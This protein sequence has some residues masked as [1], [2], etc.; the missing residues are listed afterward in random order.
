[1]DPD[2][3]KR[4]QTV[5]ALRADL[6][7][8]MRGEDNFPRQ[9]FA[10]GEY[11]MREG[12]VGNAAYILVYGR[13]QV[14]KQIKGKR[15][16]LRM[17]GPGDVLGETSILASTP[18][19]ASVLALTDVVA[20]VVTAD[21]LERE[22]DAMKP[23][24]GSFIRA[25]ARRFTDVESRA[26]KSTADPVEIANLALMNLRTWGRRGHEHGHAMSVLRLC[27]QIAKF[28][29]LSENAVLKALRQYSQFDIDLSLDRISVI[30]E[31]GLLDE[32]RRFVWA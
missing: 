8:F 17:L 27:G 20:V 4:Y 32:L 2:P 31:Q 11:L 10:K 23:W 25:L 18:R 22:V 12:E 21:A 13:C 1:M 24:M 14:C 30:D 7:G 16:S 29:G 5:E 19:T 26:S 6:L 15:E 28:S 9:R 3:G